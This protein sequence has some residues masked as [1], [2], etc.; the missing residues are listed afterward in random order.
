MLA[1]ESV[2]AGR[3]QEALIALQDLVRK[4]PGKSE[5]RIF[6]F[7]LLCVLG[8]WDRALNQLN[9][10]GDMDAGT[11]AM[12]AMYRQAIACEKQR[13]AVFAGSA[14]P[15]VMGQPEQWMAL[16]FE[17]LRLSVE[18]K[19]AEASVVRTESLEAAPATAGKLNG[20]P[21]SWIADADSRLGPM[22]EVILGGQYYWIPFHRLKVIK[23]EAPVDLR[24]VV[25]APAELE[26]PGGGRTVALIPGRYPGSEGADDALKMGRRT[27]WLAHPGDTYFGLGQRMLTTDQGEH[28]LF[29]TRTIEL[30]GAPESPA[31][32]HGGPDQ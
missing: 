24:D 10:L 5:H 30:D 1:I 22:L 23:I 2:R 8:Q 20:Q 17:S 25:W 29:E 4:E 11:L 18:G 3:P 9:V 19:H 32:G 6:L 16:L 31:V 14:R 26:F 21:F 28:A 15:I 27:E 13:A 7:Q 12:V